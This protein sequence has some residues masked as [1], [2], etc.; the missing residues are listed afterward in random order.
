MHLLTGTDRQTRSGLE[1]DTVRLLGQ[2]QTTPE[3]ETV[4]DCREKENNAPAGRRMGFRA[5][6]LSRLKT[7]SKRPAEKMSVKTYPAK[8]VKSA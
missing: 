3:K 8:T 7:R 5:D 4:I 6:G 1:G 2:Y